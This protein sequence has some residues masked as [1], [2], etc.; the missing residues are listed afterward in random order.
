[1]FSEDLTPTDKIAG[2]RRADRRYEIRLELRWKLIRRRR[3][4][5]SGTGHTIDLSSGGVLLEAGRHLPPGL[6]LELSIC[7]PVMLHNVAAMQLVTQGRIVRSVQGQVAMRMVHHEFR[8]TG[9]IP[10]RRPAS[11]ETHPGFLQSNAA[12]DLGIQ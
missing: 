9:S 4:L 6:N 12:L 3:V 2:D 10:E 8:T 11:A 5:D 7:W 1:M